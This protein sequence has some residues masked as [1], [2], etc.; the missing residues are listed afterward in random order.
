MSR[1]FMVHCVVMKEMINWCACEIRWE[2]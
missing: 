1:F 2:W